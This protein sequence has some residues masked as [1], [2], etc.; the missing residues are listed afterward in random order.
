MP[1]AKT[2]PEAIDR[3][4]L[5]AEALRLRARNY[6]Y[7]E[8]A[9]ELGIKRSTAHSYVKTAM[10]EIIREPAEEV[11]A[12]ELDRYDEMQRLVREAIVNKGE[13]DRVPHW[14]KISE[15]R[16]KL[17]GLHHKAVLD[18][19]RSTGNLSDVDVWLS[20]HLGKAG[21]APSIDLDQVTSVADFEQKLADGAE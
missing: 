12:L 17:L 4:H 1:K 21:A 7:Q 2:G 9:D 19:N 18:L 11:V 5:R 20:V 6:T 14:L 10:G 13:L 3:D 16:A 15:A 8:I